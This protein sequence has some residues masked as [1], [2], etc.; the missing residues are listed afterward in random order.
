MISIPKLLI[1]ALVIAI[2]YFLF[3]K[4]RKEKDKEVEQMVDCKEC[5]T[6]ISANEAILKSGKEYCSKECAKLK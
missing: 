6:Y 5:G 2:V 4:K 3:I 1:L